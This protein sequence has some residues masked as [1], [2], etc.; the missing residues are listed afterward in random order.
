MIHELFFE[1]E[2]NQMGRTPAYWQYRI[3]LFTI[4]ALFQPAP[5]LARANPPDIG[6]H[7]EYQ[8]L[9]RIRDQ[10]VKKLQGLDPSSSEYKKAARRLRLFNESVQARARSLGLDAGSQAS[11][12]RPANPVPAQPPREPWT[13][14]RGNAWAPPPPPPAGMPAPKIGATVLTPNRVFTTI[15]DIR[16]SDG[17][18]VLFTGEIYPPSQLF[19]QV[20]SHKGVVK[21]G[22]R[23]L[24]PNGYLDRVDEVYSNGTQQKVWTH[25]EEL[26][27]L[28]N[29]HYEVPSYDNPTLG[30]IQKGA[31][32]LDQYGTPEKVDGVFT[33][34]SGASWKIQ[35]S[36]T[37]VFD[38]SQVY[39]QTQHYGQ[40]LERPWILDPR[41][42]SVRVVSVYSNGSKHKLW[43]EDRIAY[44]SSVTYREIPSYGPIRKGTSVWS[45]TGD[46]NIEQVARVFSNGKEVRV[47]DDRHR[48]YRLNE[49]HYDTGGSG[50]NRF[51]SA[52]TLAGAADCHLDQFLHVLNVLKNR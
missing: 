51:R 43:T 37:A 36:G 47:L 41:G 29:V 21:D 33:N 4:F 28:R 1:G 35:S 48:S 49:I 44:D 11:Q 34:E 23:I 31:P 10:L 30:R 40:V 13:P 17:Y 12:P 14:P 9:L 46:G 15:T 39:V 19:Y 20:A 32:I 42:R 3:L 2:R 50:A 18:V 7:N 52:D 5:N 45:P 6:A 16:P 27:D 24:N 26:Y 8:S 22:T 25:Q 38:P